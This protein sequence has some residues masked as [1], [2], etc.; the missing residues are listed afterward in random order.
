[1]AKDTVKYKSLD[2]GCVLD[3]HPLTAEYREPRVLSSA[4]RDRR[5]AAGVVVESH[6]LF[7]SGSMV[8]LDIAFTEA[9]LVRRS[10]V[11]YREGPSCERLK[12][13]CSKTQEMLQFTG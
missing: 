2:P 5:P 1:M 10:L 9:Q 7:P 4:R 12:S 3:M 8:V 13:L 11:E 6:E